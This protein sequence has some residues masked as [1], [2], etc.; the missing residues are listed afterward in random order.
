[1]TL[2]ILDE[3]PERLKEVKERIKEFVAER[4]NLSL[5]EK[6]NRVMPVSN[7]IDFLGYIIRQDYLLVRRRV[8]NNMK[9]KLKGFESRLESEEDGM[10]IIRYD[11]ALLERL[12]S[13]LA[14]YLG[15]LKWAD[16]YGLRRAILNRYAYLKEYFSFDSGRI[17]PLY[18]YCEIFPSARSQYLY[19]ANRLRGMVI[20]FQVGCFYEFY[21]DI[22]EDVMTILRLKRLGENKR[23]ARYGFPVRLEN[24]Y[25]NRL[26]DKGIPLA[27]IRE[28]DRYIGRIKERLPVMKILKAEG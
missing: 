11:D 2:L 21:A 3:S 12:R 18:K 28:T 16:T 19:Y 13:V 7:G 24:E 17:R 4:L 9:A 27:I 14:S 6:Y 26:I 10:R 1:M 20:L 22:K 5:N 23:G 8:V 15:H 25:V